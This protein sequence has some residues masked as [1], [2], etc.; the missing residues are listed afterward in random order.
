MLRRPYGN[1]RQRAFTIPAAVNRDFVPPHHL[2]RPQHV[3][4]NEPLC[5]QSSL[6]PPRNDDALTLSLKSR[7]I[8]LREH[9][10]KSLFAYRS[11]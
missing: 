8:V 5:S 7:A 10:P 3:D 4:E 2:H 1:S 6:K 9:E 11:R